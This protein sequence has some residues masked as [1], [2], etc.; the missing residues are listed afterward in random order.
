MRNLEMLLIRH[1]E[2]TEDYKGLA[3]IQNKDWS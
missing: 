2:I 1:T 3:K